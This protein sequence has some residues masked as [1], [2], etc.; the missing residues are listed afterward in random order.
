MFCG[1]PF[2]RAA[3]WR[4]THLIGRAGVNVAEHLDVERT[5]GARGMGVL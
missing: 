2:S 5:T 1:L 3:R 4:P